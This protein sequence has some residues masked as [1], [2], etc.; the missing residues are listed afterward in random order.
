MRD[1]DAKFEVEREF[2]RLEA[3]IERTS[4]ALGKGGAKATGDA[5]DDVADNKGLWKWCGENKGKAAAIGLGLAGIAALGV[6][7]CR[8]GKDEE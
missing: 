1:L 2:A 8:R 7:A 6:Y 5:V 4:G 3:A